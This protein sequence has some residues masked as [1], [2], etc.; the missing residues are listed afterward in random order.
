[1]YQVNHSISNLKLIFLSLLGGLMVSA[2]LL[3]S[4]LVEA[5]VTCSRT[6]TANVVAMD[7]SMMFNRPGAQNILMRRPRSRGPKFTSAHHC[8]I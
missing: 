4:P 6:L 3:Y 8:R 7:Q 1:M 5:A 2:A